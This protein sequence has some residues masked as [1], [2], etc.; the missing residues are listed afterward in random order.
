[1]TDSLGGKLSGS[2]AFEAI[3]KT[4]D[5]EALDLRDD[6]KSHPGGD[7]I[8]HPRGDGITSGSPSPTPH[9]WI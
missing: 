2:V 7:D 9:I 3:G 8:T 5:H 6:M 4:G 1:M